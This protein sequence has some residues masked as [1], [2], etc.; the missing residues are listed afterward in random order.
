MQCPY[1]V[2]VQV[3][4]FGNTHLHNLDRAGQARAC[5]TV[6]DAPAADAV[7]AGLQ[8]CVLLGVQAETSLEQSARIVAASTATRVAV[9]EPARGAIIPSRDDALVAHNHAADLALHAVGTQ[10]GKVR[11]PHKVRVPRRAAGG[12]DQADSAPPA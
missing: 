11:K 9:S 4:H 3:N 5:I 7:A 12:P 1:R 6:E 2:R 8:Q 10:R